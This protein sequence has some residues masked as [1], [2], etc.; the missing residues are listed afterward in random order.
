M[1]YNK[2]HIYFLSIKKKDEPENQKGCEP[3]TWLTAGL[4]LPG[5]S[6]SSGGLVPTQSQISIRFDE[7][8][9]PHW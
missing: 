2:I 9:V 4:N 5:E 1:F 7:Y 8:I 6:P 3:T